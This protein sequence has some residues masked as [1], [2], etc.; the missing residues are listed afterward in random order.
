MAGILQEETCNASAGCGRGAAAPAA[1]SG[2]EGVKHE[3]SLQDCSC[4][5]IHPV[6]FQ[7]GA[8][9]CQIHRGMLGLQSQ[10]S[11]EQC[12]GWQ[13]HAEQGLKSRTETMQPAAA[14]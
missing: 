12:E 13:L 11:V 3:V 10:N 5:F 2:C 4:A 7:I 14:L 9:A 8:S 1:H 6:S